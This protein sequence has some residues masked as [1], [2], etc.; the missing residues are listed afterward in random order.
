M[1]PLAASSQTEPGGSR[2]LTLLESIQSLG[3]SSPILN[4]DSFS[5]PVTPSAAPVCSSSN[6]YSCSVASAGV[7]TLGEVIEVI[8]DDCNKSTPDGVATPQEKT[9]DSTKV[10]QKR[11]VYSIKDMKQSERKRKPKTPR[12]IE[13][14]SDEPLDTLEAQFLSCINDSLHPSILDINDYE[15]CYHMRSLLPKPGRQLSLDDENEYRHLVNLARTNNTKQCNV[16][17]VVEEVKRT[18]TKRKK[19][20][21]PVTLNRRTDDNSEGSATLKQS[22][23]AQDVINNF[24]KAPGNRKMEKFASEICTKYWCNHP[25]KCPHGLIY[26]IDHLEAHMALRPQHIQM[27]AM[28]HLAFSETVDIDHPPNDPLFDPKSQKE[29]PLL[30]HHKQLMKEAAGGDRSLRNFTIVNNIP[31]LGAANQ[32]AGL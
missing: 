7:Q 20:T 27:W 25:G 23:C 12:I 29:S 4:V 13:L 15:I 32:D 17:V 24:N 26:C 31:A 22:K 18:L 1:A 5:D 9:S 8:T 19:K 11:K 16:S 28:K 2:T 6:A 21:W 30:E 3:A 14:S 10:S